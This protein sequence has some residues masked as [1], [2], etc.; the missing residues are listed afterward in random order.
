MLML[1]R[2]DGGGGGGDATGPLLVD[3]TCGNCD[4][5]LHDAFFYGRVEIRS[6]LLHQEPINDSANDI[7]IA[8][9]TVSVLDATSCSRA[10]IL[11]ANQMLPPVPR[12]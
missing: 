8:L 5:A 9:L 1:G 2:Q 4:G 7:L 6:H 3:A 12:L 11:K 10:V